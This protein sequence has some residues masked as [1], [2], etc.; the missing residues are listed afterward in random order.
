V[1]GGLEFISLCQE[2]YSWILLSEYLVW[3]AKKEKESEERGSPLR[4]M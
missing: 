2:D 4:H 3:Q 1:I